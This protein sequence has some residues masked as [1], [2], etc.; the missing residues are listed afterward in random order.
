MVK[1]N[2]WFAYGST[3]KN[4]NICYCYESYFDECIKNFKFLTLT[5]IDDIHYS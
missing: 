5:D 3:F 2:I 1:A 4:K